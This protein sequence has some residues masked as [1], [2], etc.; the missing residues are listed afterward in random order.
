MPDSSPGNGSGK[1]GGTQRQGSNDGPRARRAP[2]EA[3]YNE[4]LTSGLIVPDVNVL[5]G[6]YRFNSQARDDMLSVLEN[7]GD[8]LF[9]PSQVSVEFL[10]NRG[11]LIE[12]PLLSRPLAE[13]LNEYRKKSKDGVREW[14][15]Q[16]T[17]RD[18]QLRR[19][20]RK[21]DTAFDVLT[22]DLAEVI[23]EEHGDSVGSAFNDPIL[24]SLNRILEGRVG[25]PLEEAEYRQFLAEATHRTASYTLPGYRDSPRS[26][27]FAGDYL[28]WHQILREARIKRSD[29]LFVTGDLKDD[30]WQ[31][32]SGRIQ[33]PRPELVQEMRAA[34]GG[35]LFMLRPDSFLIYAQRF[36]EVRVSA[37]SVKEVEHVADQSDSEEPEKF[38]IN[39]ISRS[40]DKILAATEGR[41]KAARRLLDR[42]SIYEVSGPR[43]T[44]E[45]PRLSDARSFVSRRFDQILGEVMV[46]VFHSD[47][48]LTV[49]MQ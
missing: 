33:G 22:R 29:V 13:T 31:V 40:W 48:Y 44:I 30:W 11:R 10:H 18:E 36:L 32:E 5:L 20:L 41:N 46:E 25:S 42:A 45:F 26:E 19:I 34:A 37:E 23:A 8:R 39:L 43:V 9:V 15:L 27:G 49:K 3:D 28:I 38:D 17:F 16:E 4:V 7:L 12:D 14:M 6:L 21:V 1:P 2:T 47:V 24:A 35:K